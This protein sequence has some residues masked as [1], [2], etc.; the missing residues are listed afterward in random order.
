MPRQTTRNRFVQPKNKCSLTIQK[1]KERFVCHKAEHLVSPAT[2]SLQSNIL[3]SLPFQLSSGSQICKRIYTV[4]F[5]ISPISLSSTFSSSVGPT[6]SP[7]SHVSSHT[8]L[9]KQTERS[10]KL[11]PTRTF[12][13]LMA[14][15]VF[16]L[17]SQKYMHLSFALFFISQP[18]RCHLWKNTLIYS[19]P[20]DSNDH[21]PIIITIINSMILKVL[22]LSSLTS[23]SFPRPRF[24]ERPAIRISQELSHRQS[25]GC[26]LSFL[27]DLN[28]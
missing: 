3:P 1:A 11:S 17:S 28:P 2:S 12:P 26:H 9:L 14:R 24:A 6:A 5:S 8:F 13:N 27:I 15:T 18:R 10:T 23:C 16:H 20:F 7:S 22:K 4:Q 19:I 25:I 21:R